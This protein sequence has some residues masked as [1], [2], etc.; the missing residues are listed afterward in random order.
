MLV[1][2]FGSVAVGD[3]DGTALGNGR[4]A[5]ILAL[6]ALRPG[7]VVSVE[8][9]VDELWGADASGDSPHALRVAVSRL[10]SHLSTAGLPDVVATRPGGYALDLP[11]DEVDLARFEDLAA[12][13]LGT[14]QPDASRA[15]LEEALELWTDDPLAAF[16][17]ADFA[18]AARDR[19]RALRGDALRRWA[20]LA[21][22]AGRAA[23]V[24]AALPAVLRDDPSQEALWVALATAVRQE[25]DP[26]E[27]L[28][29][30]G[31][32][33]SALAE[34]GLP[35]G[36]ELL[37]LERGLRDEL[38]PDAP[39]DPPHTLPAPIDAFIGRERVV[40][41]IG[42]LLGSR[43]LL[44]LVGPGGC[45]K[46]RLATE[47]GARALERFDQRVW[48]VDLVRADAPAD[49][50]G[51]IVRAIGLGPWAHDDPAAA[52]RA[53]LADR[54]ALL[55]LDNCEHVI[56]AAAAAA[57]DLLRACPGLRVLATSREALRV[58]GEHVLTVP[59]LAVPDGPVASEQADGVPTRISR[60]PAVA[61]FVERTR[62]ADPG[63]ALTAENAAD[64]ARITRA[65]DGIPLAIELAAVR[66]RTRSVAE[67]ADRL[68]DV[69]DALGRGSRTALPRHRT[70]Q[71]AL[72]WSHELLDSEEQRLFAAMGV[73]RSPFGIDAAA[74]VRGM[75]PTAIEPALAG[76]VEKSMVLVARGRST[77]YRLL[78]PVRQF[79]AA[80][81]RDSG[82]LDAATARR[83][84]WFAALAVEAGDGHRRFEQVG[85]RTRIRAD[86]PNLLASV[87]SL[88]RGGQRDLAADS[89]LALGR[90][91]Q[92]F[93]LY[94][95]GRRMLRAA[96]A[97]IDLDDRRRS[98]LLLQEGWLAAHQGDYS[99]ARTLASESLACVDPSHAP[100]RAAAENLLGSV[101][102]QRGDDRAARRWLDAAIGSFAAGDSSARGMAMVNLAVV[103]AYA[104]RC[105]DALATVAAVR[106]LPAAPDAHWTR[107]VE[108]L[109]ARMRGDR[110][111][112]GDPLDDSIDAFERVGSAFHASLAR[113]E[114][115]LVAHESG[116]DAFAGELAARVLADADRGTAPLVPHIRARVLT[117]RL[118][119]ARGD[120]DRAA[121]EARRAADEASR[122]GSVGAAAESAEAVALLVEHHDSAGAERLVAAAGALRARLELARDDWELARFGP[123]GPAPVAADAADLAAQAHELVLAA[124]AAS[125]ARPLNASRPMR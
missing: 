40:D 89:A 25:Q 37:A 38:A 102:A 1:R 65:L 119:A 120:V 123:L 26:A 5:A 53:L 48:F 70:L 6:L 106:A 103:H 2:L 3:G 62:S 81:L 107:F 30:V 124:L 104:G 87:E 61:L 42:H 52:L 125:P 100:G 47:V 36:A 94:D 54:S 55:L 114:R 93:G 49:V 19:L 110:G 15:T 24:A 21:T 75:T 35:A 90:Y 23:D 78:E 68:D 84:R 8:R 101:E 31:R 115:A 69:F 77:R 63:F 112:A 57:Q 46:T 33:R 34:T 91:W 7:A 60:S 64:V 18:V 117:A 20:D 17:Y 45:G 74:A 28:R 96:R 76:L 67:L 111:A 10:R 95:E 4:S 41:A 118:L 56:D 16:P 59:S 109:V 32:A 66:T 13:G 9:L 27:A 83:D 44:T 122:T 92:E 71:A 113:L 51:L 22:D 121:D 108:G 98:A 11:R 105:D 43:R 14:N 39:H 116:D 86:R 97:P 72:D 80:K 88:V 73:L 50:P 99:S 82:A 29:Q 58:P 12:R 79:A 85:W